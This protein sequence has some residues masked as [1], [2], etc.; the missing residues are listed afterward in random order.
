MVT[1]AG[2]VASAALH[3]GVE[4]PLLAFSGVVAASGIGLA[5]ASVPSLVFSR[6]VAWLVFAPCALSALNAARYGHAEWTTLGLAAATGAALAL[7]R[8]GLNT[9]EAQAS[10]APVAFRR[11]LLWASTITACVSIGAGTM[12]AALL[13]F[14]DRGPVVGLAA[15][16][17][18]L[19]LSAFG[20]LRMRAWGILL[21]AV[22]SMATLVAALF[23]DGFGSRMLELA[24]IP[25]LLLLAP[26]L[27]ARLG[28]V[29]RA[30]PREASA[31]DLGTSR[32]RIGDVAS[33]ARVRVARGETDD[34]LLGAELAA[35]GGGADAA[36]AP[37]AGLR[38]SLPG[39]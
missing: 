1:A 14:H 39:V 34:D 8:S 11:Y 23:Q 21:G 19:A 30:A 35:A 15:L 27:A 36:H 28:L 6:A 25:G 2:G 16:A 17:A 18:S 5:R 24:A 3:N 32:T 7:S 22:T 26:I 10:F 38:A 31:V 29:A 9:A 20:V 13:S 37:G 33:P 4:W 12:A